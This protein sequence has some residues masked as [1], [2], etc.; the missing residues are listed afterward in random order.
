MLD[1]IRMFHL[2]CAGILSLRAFFV[3]VLMNREWHLQNNLM[4]MSVDIIVVDYGDRGRYV[5]N[6]VSLDDVNFVE[7]GFCVAEP[8]FRLKQSEAQQLINE[9]WREGF[10]PKDGSGAVAHVESMQGHLD[11]MRKLAFHALKVPKD[12]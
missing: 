1:G 8:T 9:L 2:G 5:V 4:S 12:E 10:R 6:P 7:D 3:E 11:D